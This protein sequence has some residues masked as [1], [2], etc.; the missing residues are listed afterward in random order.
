M[1]YTNKQTNKQTG[2]QHGINTKQVSQA[3][4]NYSF[5]KSLSLIGSST[6]EVLC[7]SSVFTFRLNVYPM[8]SVAPFRLLN[9]FCPA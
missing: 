8:N 2:N 9:S 5:R 4:K 1:E 3:V 6:I 7:G